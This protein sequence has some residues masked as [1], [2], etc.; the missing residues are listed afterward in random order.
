[1]RSD[2]ELCVIKFCYGQLSKRTPTSQIGWWWEGSSQ[3][4][5]KFE[6]APFYFVPPT[7]TQGSWQKKKKIKI[8]KK[9]WFYFKNSKFEK[10]KKL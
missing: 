10:K 3:Q 6:S 4:V 5:L 2:S 8:L 1:L 7:S 9:I